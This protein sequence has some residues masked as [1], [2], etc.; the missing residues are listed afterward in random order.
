MWL[1]ARPSNSHYILIIHNMY[2]VYTAHIFDVGQV[3]DKK[4]PL[5]GENKLK[6]NSDRWAKLD[7]Y[8]YIVGNIECSYCSVLYKRRERN[9]TIHL[10]TKAIQAQISVPLCPIPIILNMSTWYAF[11]CMSQWTE[12]NVAERNLHYPYISKLETKD[13]VF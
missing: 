12:R 1:Q 8:T 11:A 9:L 13:T 5:S 10:K 3:C 6:Q 4:V 2:I 7:M